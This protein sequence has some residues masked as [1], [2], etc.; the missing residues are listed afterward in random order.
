[1]ERRNLLPF[2]TKGSGW[3]SQINQFIT[4]RR[5]VSFQFENRQFIVK[6]AE[7]RKELLQS[8][9]LRYDVFQREYAGKRFPVGFDFDRFDSHADHLIVIDQKSKRVVGSYRMISNCSKHDYYSSTEFELESFIAKEGVKLELSRCCI[10]RDY[11]NGVI[12]VLL[13]RGV[14]QYIRAV[15]ARYLFGLSSVQSTSADL[16]IQIAAR[17]KENGQILEDVNIM[18]LPAFHLKDTLKEPDNSEYGLPLPGLF[19]AYLKMGGQVSAEA[20]LDRNFRC[21]DFLTIVDVDKMTP[22]YKRKFVE[23]QL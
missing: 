21:L 13:L 18:P 7:N 19:E 1:M 9:Q 8:L 22:N 15:N 11:R 20:A 17:L 6:T 16:A 14:G 4:F 10:H 12:M 2:F 5:K 23:C 3:L